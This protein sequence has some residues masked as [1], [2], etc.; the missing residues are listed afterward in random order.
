MQ[1][2]ILPNESLIRLVTEGKQGMMEARME[3][4]GEGGNGDVFEQAYF[5]FF[6]YLVNG[7]V[8]FD[9]P[10]R[11]QSKASKERDD[12]EGVGVTR[13]GRVRITSSGIL[14]NHRHRRT[15]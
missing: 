11:A 10:L 8:K 6:T 5:L 14:C 12:S 7:A 13:F 15:P 3:G 9:I 1:S 2:E 4:G